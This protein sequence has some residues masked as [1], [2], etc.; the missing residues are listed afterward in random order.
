MRSR[1]PLA[2]AGAYRSYPGPRLR[3][4]RAFEARVPRSGAWVPVLVIRLNG[5]E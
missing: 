4:V 1:T 5:A 3:F 2:C